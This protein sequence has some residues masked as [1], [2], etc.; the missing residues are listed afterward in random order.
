MAVKGHVWIKQ[1]VCGELDWRCRRGFKRV[2][3]A[4][5]AVDKA[6]Y[7]T[8]IR[9]GNHSSGSTHYLG[10]AFDITKELPIEDIRNAV[11]TEGGWFVLDE[12]NHYHIQREPLF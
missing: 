10:L 6:M 5:F 11:D 12:G 2:A 9:E 8:S 1:G 4:H 3:D 7:V